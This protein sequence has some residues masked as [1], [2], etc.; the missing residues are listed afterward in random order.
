M[1]AGRWRWAG[2]AVEM[3]ALC[4][5]SG[6][7]RDDGN[8]IFFNFFF[9]VDGFVV[10]PPW[11][12][13]STVLLP[14]HRGKSPI[15]G[16]GWEGTEHT[17]QHRGLCFTPPKLSCRKWSILIQADILGQ[18]FLPVHAALAGCEQERSNA[19]WGCQLGQD[20]GLCDAP[21]LTYSPRQHPAFFPLLWLL[22]KG[23]TPDPS[24]H[25]SY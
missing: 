11:P 1:P 25:R 17:L 22:Q 23:P 14:F 16:W 6:A 13:S 18:V 2:G 15:R 3:K 9:F 19:G 5:P 10:V 21:E 7:D 12:G 4:S 20:K 24:G 8:F